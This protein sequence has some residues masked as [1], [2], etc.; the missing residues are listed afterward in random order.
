MIKYLPDFV[1]T[2]LADEFL[3]T[4]VHKR[5]KGSLPRTGVVPDEFGV[6]KEDSRG[7]LLYFWNDVSIL[8][9][10]KAWI[11]EVNNSGEGVSEVVVVVLTVVNESRMECCDRSRLITM[12]S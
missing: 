9:W 5:M 4:A 2:F 12:Q 7:C 6:D 8:T 3:K 1:A 10:L 11:M